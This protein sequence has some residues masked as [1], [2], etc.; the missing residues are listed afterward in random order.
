[1]R[2]FEHLALLAPVIVVAVG[3][4]AALVVVWSRVGWESLQRHELPWRVVALAV[5]LLA[6][7]GLL[8]ALGLKLPRE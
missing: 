6:L 4:V 3:A 2:L 8:S 7:I 5:G 1:V